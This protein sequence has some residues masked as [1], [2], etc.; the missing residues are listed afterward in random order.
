MV[1]EIHRKG[2]NPGVSDEEGVYYAGG[3][4]TAKRHADNL[5]LAEGGHVASFGHHS[6][7][8]QI[9]QDKKKQ[10][11]RDFL[12]S[13]LIQ[14]MIDDLE[15]RND[16]LD[17]LIRETEEELK[18]AE[19]S[20]EEIIPKLK[21][22]EKQ[23]TICEQE[24]REAEKALE[25]IQEKIDT[26][27]S[28]KW[29]AFKALP[30]DALPDHLVQIKFDVNN[31]DRNVGSVEVAVYQKDGKYYFI[32]PVTEQP[33]EITDEKQK[34]ELGKQLK[35]GRKT[36]DTESDDMKDLIKHIHE[37]A[38]NV[39]VHALH[40]DEHN[41][42]FET[43]KK[44]YEDKKDKYE[45]QL[46]K[47]NTLREQ[48]QAKDKEIEDLKNKRSRYEDE[49]EQNKIQL[50]KLY[51]ERNALH[52]SSELEKSQLKQDRK[53]FYQS[54]QEHKGA[55]EKYLEALEA[56]DDYTKKIQETWERY[57]DCKKDERALRKMGVALVAVIHRDPAHPESHAHMVHTVHR[58]ESGYYYLDASDLRQNLNADSIKPGTKAVE[59]LSGGP[60]IMEAVR[61]YDEKADKFHHTLHEFEEL[62]KEA[63]SLEGIEQQ[64]K[65]PQSASD[66][67]FSNEKELAPELAGV[68]TGAAGQ[69][70]TEP[71]G[72]E[73]HHVPTK[74]PT[75]NGGPPT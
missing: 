44:N 31:G 17:N 10:E 71:T 1:D 45:T 42:E 57:Q 33:Q 53:E 50:E 4:Q 28:L 19:K 32:N 75:K 49:L 46:E 24:L 9:D 40:A 29:E 6:T 7:Q 51:K 68:F 12:R 27:E 54:L 35:D 65:R 74:T 41:E 3:S 36:Y 70:Y 14:A 38:H 22:A 59:D 39:M 52:T 34:D 55:A 48:L 18:G 13:L 11:S 15:S 72:H 37:A 25:K 47:V 60:L 20:R 64:R 73:H 63:E 21:E 5:L 67:V 26:A 8:D 16:E 66:V 62:N 56:R 61:R 69:L 58:D 30:A 43:A 2:S 23:L